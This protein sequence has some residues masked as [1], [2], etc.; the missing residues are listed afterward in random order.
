LGNWVDGPVISQPAVS[1]YNT[2]PQP[3]PTNKPTAPPTG[4]GVSVVPHKTTTGCSIAIKGTGFTDNGAVAISFYGIPRTGEISGRGLAPTA[5]T[6]PVVGHRG[7]ERIA[8]TPT[9]TGGTFTYQADFP[10]TSTDAAHKFLNIEVIVKDVTT[11][12][13]LHQTLNAAYWIQ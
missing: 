6:K 4:F 9:V 5:L 10:F 7:P 2:F 11:S 12:Q 3:T 8:A 13:M 1:W